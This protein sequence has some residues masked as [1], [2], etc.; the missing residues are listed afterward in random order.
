MGLTKVFSEGKYQKLCAMR[1]KDFIEKSNQVTKK[2]QKQATRLKKTKKV[3]Q[4]QE[5]LYRY[6]F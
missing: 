1:E 5:T 6:I 2:I 3:I 4:R